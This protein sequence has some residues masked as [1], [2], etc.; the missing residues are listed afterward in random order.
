MLCFVKLKLNANVNIK[1]ELA[2]GRAKVYIVCVFSVLYS[3]M[4]NYFKE[5]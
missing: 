5:I 4:L 2:A 3:M 1:F